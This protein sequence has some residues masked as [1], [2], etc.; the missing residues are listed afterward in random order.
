MCYGL[1]IY[2][3]Y[4]KK[5]DYPLFLF[6]LRDTK[7][8]GSEIRFPSPYPTSNFVFTFFYQVLSQLMHK[9]SDV[10][11]V[12]ISEIWSLKCWKCPGTSQDLFCQQKIWET[13]GQFSVECQKPGSY[14]AMSAD[15]KGCFVTEHCFLCC[16]SEASRTDW[17]YSQFVRMSWKA[18]RISIFCVMQWLI[19]SEGSFRMSEKH[20]AILLFRVLVRVKKIFFKSAIL[21]ANTFQKNVAGLW[22]C[23]LKGREAP[24]I[25]RCP[26]LKRNRKCQ[27]LLK[28][29]FYWQIIHLAW[30]LAC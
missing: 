11:R 29:E 13:L 19:K 28:N 25:C 15:F 22:C 3:V 20:I 26:W 6:F 23:T 16:N 18:K 4:Y 27:R 30:K 5:R 14:Q 2:F 24:K 9:S 17:A 8:T 12:E 21:V 1:N 7:T 10:W